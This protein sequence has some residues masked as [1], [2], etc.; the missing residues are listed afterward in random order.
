MAINETPT[1]NQY[2]ATAGQ[3]VFPYTFEI[4]D[5]DDIAVDKNG[6]LLSKGTDYSVTGVN[7]DNGGNVTLA[8]GATAG[9]ILTLYRDM[10]LERT[11]D[12]QQNGDFL[13]DEVNDDFDRLWAA[14][15]QLTTTSTSAL[16]A[17]IDDPVLNS[18]N[19]ELADVTSRA[20]RVLGF[21]SQ[22][23][24]TYLAASIASGDLNYVPNVASMQALT[25]LTVGTDAV[26]TAEY[27]TANGGGGFYSVVLTSSVTPNGYNIIQSVAEPTLSF[28]LNVGI[29][30]DMAQWGVNDASDAA[31]VMQSAWDQYPLK[32]QFWPDG[33]FSMET[34]V[35]LYS[36]ASGVF[37]Q[38]PQIIGAGIGATLFNNKVSNSPML[39]IDSGGTPGSNF[40]QGCVLRGFKVIRNTVQATQKA[41]QLKTSYQVEIEQVH[42]DGMTGDGLRIITSVGDNDGSNMVNMKNCRI[43]NCTGWGIDS[44]GD[45]NFNEFSFFHLEMVFI[46]NCG[47]DSAAFQPPSGGFKHKAQIMTMNQCAFTLNKNCA[48]WLPGEAGLGQT[49]DIQDTTFENNEKRNIFCRGITQFKA[50]NIQQYHNDSFVGTVGIEFEGSSFLIEQVLIDGCVVRAT[51]GNNAFT[52]FKI[53]GANADLETCRVKRVRWDNFDYA[54]Q[55]RFDGWQF[56]FVENNLILETS[57]GSTLTLK[58]SAALGKG[59]KVPLRLSGGGGGTPSTSGE[60]IEHQ[61]LSLTIGNGSLSASTRYYCYIY[62]NNN[63]AALELSTTAFVTDSNTGYPVKSGD[64]TRYYVGSVETDGGSNFLTSAGGWL[65]PVVTYNNVQ[66]GVA[67]YTWFDTT[68]TMR[69]KYAVAP[70]SNSDG[71]AI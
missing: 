36:G 30:L 58:P 35:Q 8:I 11:T 48:L 16:R 1:R 37:N 42:I 5:D 64:A 4:F 62:D 65:N 71:T 6:S 38:G 51:V 13:A 14:I 46:Q 27:S 69:A 31:L 45:P 67:T 57:S 24:V 53:S 9:D 29:S 63:V 23:L 41:I 43:E 70:T 19:T 50:R 49:V 22:G 40:L 56:D 21:D 10:P 25:G 2:T 55:T 17:A 26:I 44:A 3:T 39:D 32:A 28:K 68:T 54:G 47:T 7:L 60:W 34:S 12:Y 33:E 66:G 15:Q 18:S 61:V 59:N 20:G 52:A